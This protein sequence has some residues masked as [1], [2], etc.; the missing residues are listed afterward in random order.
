MATQPRIPPLP[1]TEWTDEVRDFFAIMEGPEARQ[2]GSRFNIILTFA[3]YPLMAGAFNEYYKR[4]LSHSTLPLRLREIITLRV[5]WRHRCEYEWIQHVA[6]AK[7]AGLSD[8][9]ID[10]IRTEP[11]APIWTELERLL[12]QAVDELELRSRIEEPT[13]NALSR[14]LSR[15]QLMELPFIVGSYTLL[16]YA[17]NSFGVQPEGR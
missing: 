9:H 6:I 11:S 15:K 17:V 10:A 2:N 16:C 7:S 13:W 5:A 14:H 1:P 3:H 4:F 12:I 8:A